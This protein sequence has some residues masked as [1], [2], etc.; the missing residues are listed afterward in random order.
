MYNIIIFDI[1]EDMFNR[2]KSLDIHTYGMFF[3]VFPKVNTCLQ[4]RY[5]SNSCR[6]YS[7]LT[8]SLHQCLWRIC[9]REE[10][11]QTVVQFMQPDTTHSLV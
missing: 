9:Q 6:E 11:T 8:Y 4:V 5:G 7:I 2:G 3:G 1:T 10:K